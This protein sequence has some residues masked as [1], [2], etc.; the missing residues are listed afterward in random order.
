VVAP[1]SDLNP[2]HWAG[3]YAAS[4][5]DVL[6]LHAIRGGRCTCRRECGRNAGKHPI[7]DHGK[8]DATTDPTVITSWWS[9]WPW[10]S[11]G[12]RPPVG[13]VV[14]DVDPRNHGATE[15]LSLTREHGQ[16]PPTLTAR[17][18]SGGFHIWLSYGG[19]ARGRLC[20]G[21]DIKTHAGYVVAPPSP[22]VSGRRYEWVTG[23]PTAPAPRW[24]RRILDPPPVTLPPRPR[25]ASGERQLDGLLRHIAE[26]P[27]GELNARLYWSSCRA[28]E[29]G[30]DVEPLVALAVSKGHPER[31]ARNTAAS[32]AKAPPRRVGGAR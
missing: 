21:V 18:G 12:I 14:L 23:L 25:A 15:L 17:T 16:L 5:L 9:R 7:T 29:S 1:V 27:G 28:H 6:P 32:A 20:P 30:L 3:R 10:A 11:V 22:H 31:G 13:V 2:G 8:D 24:V 19:R 26:D 4:G